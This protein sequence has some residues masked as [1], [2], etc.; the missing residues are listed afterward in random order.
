MRNRLALFGAALV[1]STAVACSDDAAK[2]Q[3]RQPDSPLTTIASTSGTQSKSP[4]ADRPLASPTPDG[5]TDARTPDSEGKMV[6]H[7]VGPGDTLSG[8]ADLHASTVEAILGANGRVAGE[9]VIRI[10][11]EL[12]VPAGV[13]PPLLDSVRATITTDNLNVR[14]GPSLDHMVLGKL[15]SGAEVEVTGRTVGSGWLALGGLGWVFFDPSWIELEEDLGLIRLLD[16]RD[17]STTGPTHPVDLRTGV[18][19]VDEAINVVLSRDPA[20]VQ[21][22]IRLQS[23]GCTTRLGLG[24]PPAC[25]EGVAEG[26][27]IDRLPISNCEGGGVLREHV[28]WAVERWLAAAPGGEPAQVLGTYAV[29]RAH[30]QSST[31]FGGAA[32]GV[33]FSDEGGAGRLAWVAGDGGITGLTTGCGPT[34]PGRMMRSGGAP[35]DFLLGPAV[36][37]QLEPVN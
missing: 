14:L 7:V 20:R 11:E 27:P 28:G 5:G 6:T 24:G 16:P 36:P 34:S 30:G 18:A 19:A 21:A 23:L 8:I 12:Q 9:I 4:S 10:G 13:R 37:N 35:P 1:L 15:N 32:Y 17:P 33:V 25:P 26:T 3:E 29:V 2:D 31:I 22:L